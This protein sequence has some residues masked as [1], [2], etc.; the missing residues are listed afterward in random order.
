MRPH[1]SDPGPAS[2][3]PLSEASQPAP[4]P[5]LPA[6]P[7]QP[8]PLSP[9]SA[10]P[11]VGPLLHSTPPWRPMLLYSPILHPIAS[12]LPSWAG[13]EGP[14]KNK[15]LKVKHTRK[16]LATSHVLDAL[17][18]PALTAKLTRA[19]RS[20]SR[21]QRE[22]ERGRREITERK[23]SILLLSTARIRLS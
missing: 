2:Q 17:S 18:C 9:T 3:V 19:P 6:S 12:S 8:G 21:S 14:R 4:R 16:T 23:T 22:I 15:L 10:L 11:L 7:V 20:S 13:V 5:S 1:H